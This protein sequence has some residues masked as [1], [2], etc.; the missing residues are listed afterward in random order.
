MEEALKA[1]FDDKLQEWLEELA[2]ASTEELRQ[3]WFD[4]MKCAVDGLGY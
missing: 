1:A 4:G 2:S 3:K